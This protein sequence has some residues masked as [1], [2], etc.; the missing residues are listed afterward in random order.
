[1]F[2][3]VRKVSCKFWITG[4]AVLEAVAKRNMLPTDVMTVSIARKCNNVCQMISWWAKK[5]PNS[6]DISDFATNVVLV[7]FSA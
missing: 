6:I 7:M 1:M 2:S 5:L 3:I 4:I